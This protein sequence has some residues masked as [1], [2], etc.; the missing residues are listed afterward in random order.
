MT[1]VAEKGCYKGEEVVARIEKGI[2]PIMPQCL[3]S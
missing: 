1:V 2:M 3:I